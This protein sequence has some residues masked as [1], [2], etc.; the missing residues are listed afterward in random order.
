MVP[1]CQNIKQSSEQ[2]PVREGKGKWAARAVCFHAQNRSVSGPLSRGACASGSSVPGVGFCVKAELL[3]SRFP[4]KTH[5]CV[6]P[7]SPSS[8][9]SGCWPTV[10]R[11]KPAQFL[12]A[13][14]T[15]GRLCSLTPCPSAGTNSS[16]RR[17]FGGAG[18]QGAVS[19][20]GRS[21]RPRECS[22]RQQGL[23]GLR[24]D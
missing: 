1:S 14:A 20:R 22:H 11:H 21:L 7:V 9:Q 17:P 4:P 10:A 16:S 13:T 3:R 2:T 5:R 12:R 6:V 24:W 8:S 18:I 15:Q 19:S 23:E